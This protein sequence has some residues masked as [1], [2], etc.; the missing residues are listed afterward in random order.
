MLNALTPDDATGAAVPEEL[1]RAFAQ[2]APA[3]NVTD[4]A[5]HRGSRR[6]G[7]RTRRVGLSAALKAAVAVLVISSG[8]VA[9]AAADVLPGPAQRAAHSLL[10]GFGVPA[11]HQTPQTHE[12][13]APTPSYT[14]VATTN[15]AQPD[16]SHSPHAL[17]STDSK[18]SGPN[19][20]AASAH[21]GA[22]ASAPADNGN[23]HP[24]QTASHGH[25][26]NPTP[27]GSSAH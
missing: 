1:L 24:T 16:A 27:H 13:P 10:G 17:P 4:G 22:S 6:T 23:G 14:L 18:C 5:R 7:T 11:P 12:S 2:H 19:S 15:A 21:C 20:H 9:A 26:P 25:D 8:T 3:E